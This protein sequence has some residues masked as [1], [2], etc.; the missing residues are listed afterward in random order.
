MAGRDSRS[1]LSAQTRHTC[2]KSI[3]DRFLDRFLSGIFLIGEVWHRDKPARS[4]SEPDPKWER[5][6]G[7]LGNSLLKKVYVRTT[8]FVGDVVAG[9][10]L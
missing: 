4:F 5:G 1:H 8:V 3:G 10:F 6:E 7:E 9:Q 2:L